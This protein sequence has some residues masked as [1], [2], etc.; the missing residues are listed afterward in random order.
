MTTAER[1][2]SKVKID[3]R[4]KDPCWIWT[5]SRTHSGYG[6][7]WAD[8][9]VWRAHR[10]SVRIFQDLDI[11]VGLQVLHSCDTPACVNPDHLRVG[12]QS[13]NMKDMIRKGRGKNQF[14]YKDAE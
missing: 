8:G 2:L 13:E 11:S 4:R 14:G 10:L 12:T 9:K 7:I 3:R 1:L 6:Q 5:G